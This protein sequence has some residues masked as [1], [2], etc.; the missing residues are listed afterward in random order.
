MAQLVV[1][2]IGWIKKLQM[3]D[4]VKSLR[5][6]T[7]LKQLWCPVAGTCIGIWFAFGI[8]IPILFSYLGDETTVTPEDV[9]KICFLPSMGVVSPLELGLFD[10]ESEIT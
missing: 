1:G 4:F 5:M 10:K 9:E 2:L 6:P 7:F 3:R 8:Q